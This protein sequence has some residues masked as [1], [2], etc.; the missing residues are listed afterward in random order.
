[1]ESI[2][3]ARGE[4]A[5]TAFRW[6]IWRSTEEVHSCKTSPSAAA[7]TESFLDWSVAF[8][9]VEAIA[10][11]LRAHCNRRNTDRRRNSNSSPLTYSEE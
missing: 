8:S 11:D 5:A 4:A 2:T 6:P 7:T 1:M 3:A 9:G 10:M